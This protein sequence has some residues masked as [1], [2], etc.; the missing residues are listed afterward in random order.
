MFTIVHGCQGQPAERTGLMPRF[1]SVSSSLT[2]NSFRKTSAQGDA[3]GVANGARDSNGKE[4][5][6]KHAALKYP[7]P[8][9]WRMMERD[10]LYQ[11]LVY[12]RSPNFHFGIAKGCKRFVI[13]ACSCMDTFPIPGYMKIDNTWAGIKCHSLLPSRLQG[14]LPT[15]CWTDMVLWLSFL[16]P[17]L[18]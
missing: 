16:I 3:G 10:R 9:W 7:P 11:H 5:S 4:D 8:E 6:W 18:L 13:E 15:F 14:A 1:H 2:S 12:C 17:T